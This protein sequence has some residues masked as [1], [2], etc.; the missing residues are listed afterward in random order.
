MLPFQS[1]ET[2]W[3]R[4]KEPLTE[5]AY[6]RGTVIEHGIEDNVSQYTAAAGRVKL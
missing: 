2:P 1:D 5:I 4:S 3:M 6:R